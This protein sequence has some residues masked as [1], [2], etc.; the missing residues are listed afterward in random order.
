MS[1]ESLLNVRFTGFKDSDSVFWGGS[2]ESAF[3]VSNSPVWVHVV[4]GYIKK[5][6]TENPGVRGL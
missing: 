2:Q 6:W 5:H 3:E 1:K 4:S